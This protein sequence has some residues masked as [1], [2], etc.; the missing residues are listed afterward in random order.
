MGGSDQSEAAQ[1]A[2]TQNSQLSEQTYGLGKEALGGGLSYL[3]S[4]YRGGG[5]NQSAKFQAMQSQTMDQMAGA[6]PAAR[7]QAMAGVTSQKVTSGLDE[8]NKLRSML[9]GQGLQT[10]NLAEQASKQSTSAISG[11]YGGNQTLNTIEG[12]GALGSTVYGAGKQAGWWGQTANQSPGS[13]PGGPGTGTG[14]SGGA[15]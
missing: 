14:G 11:M 8:M 4:Q 5:Y 10:T 15:Y 6:N 1:S 12:I 9:A 7:A 13:A 2:F 3:T